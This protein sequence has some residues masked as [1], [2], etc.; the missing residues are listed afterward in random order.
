MFLRDCKWT[1]KKIVKP[2]F[3]YFTKNV[4]ARFPG[5]LYSGQCVRQELD[6]KGKVRGEEDLTG[7][8]RAEGGVI[9]ATVL[10][11][12]ILRLLASA[13]RRR[14]H[15]ITKVDLEERKKA[16]GQI[17]FF[18]MLLYIANFGVCVAGKQHT[19]VNYII[20]C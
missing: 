12:F 18:L 7:F 19:E 13:D 2:S 10:I 16:G 11:V 20:T 8:I 14:S 3:L 1:R 4:T 9:C 17:F 15:P 5:S 6:N